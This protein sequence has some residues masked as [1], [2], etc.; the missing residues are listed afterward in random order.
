MNNKY[1]SHPREN[2]TI[3]LPR[4]NWWRRL[5]QRCLLN[6]ASYEMWG[7]RRV[8]DFQ[9]SLYCSKWSAGRLKFQDYVCLTHCWVWDCWQCA[10]CNSAFVRAFL[11][12]KTLTAF[13]DVFKTLSWKDKALL[14]KLYEAIWKGW[15][16]RVGAVGWETVLQ[17]GRSRVRIPISTSF[18]PHYGPVVDSN[19]NK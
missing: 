4:T 8:S 2:T 10:D 13:T 16:A 1:I 12:T 3:T 15:G 6:V 7:K 18:R 17:A 19:R 14:V 9:Y 5:R 11:L